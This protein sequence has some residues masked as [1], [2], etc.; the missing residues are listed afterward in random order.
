MSLGC[1]VHIGISHTSRLTKIFTGTEFL[2]D[3]SIMGQVCAV[4]CRQPTPCRFCDSIRAGG[5]T[6]CNDID[7]ELASP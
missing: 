5:T 7:P 3:Q 4:V 1:A 2:L 6:P